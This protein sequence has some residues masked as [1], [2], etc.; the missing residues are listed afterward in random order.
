VSAEDETGFL[1]EGFYTME[2]TLKLTDNYL[3]FY[4]KNTS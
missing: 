4:W 1:I 3:D 2:D